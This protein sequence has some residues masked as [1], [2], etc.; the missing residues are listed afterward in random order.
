MKKIIV[1][2]ST[3]FIFGV[4][5]CPIYGSTNNNGMKSNQIINQNV[6]YNT[7]LRTQS[8]DI[9]CDGLGPYSQQ[10]C[11]VR[12]VLRLWIDS[13]SQ[14]IIRYEIVSVSITYSSPQ[15]ST[16]ITNCLVT[17]T[18]SSTVC[19]HLEIAWSASGIYMPMKTQ[20]VF[21]YII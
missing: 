18:D 1:I 6:Q 12:V 3:L 10:Y 14:E 8:I 17:R 5:T 21:Y 13:T 20:H 2:I 9:K 16:Y 15:I 19:V 4:S 7:I 11:I